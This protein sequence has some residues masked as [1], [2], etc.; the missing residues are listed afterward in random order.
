METSTPLPALLSD[1]TA[2]ARQ[3]GLNDTQ[4]CRVAGVRKETL[5]RLRRRDN[6]DLG[7]LA[8][9]ADAA[10]ARLSVT[11]VTASPGREVSKD[12]HLPA[13]V[14][15][16]YEAR[17]LD[18]LCS[19]R[20]DPQT[21]LAEGAPFFMAGLAAMAASADGFDRRRLLWLAEQLHP[22]SSQPDVF[23]LWL[24]RSPVRPSR[25]LPMLQQRLNRH[26]A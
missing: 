24:E 6:C 9:L 18:L 14:S 25:F 26:A 13:Q 1:L 3:R 23:A 11:E 10:G 21:W 17:L 16:E 7:T 5:S 20:L 12:G 15:R 2:L 8:A 4:W 19:A 22:G